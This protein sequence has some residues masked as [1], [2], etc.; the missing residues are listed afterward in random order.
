V[1]EVTGLRRGMKEVDDICRQDGWE[2]MKKN[3]EN[4]IKARKG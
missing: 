2:I 3:R 1:D 4:D